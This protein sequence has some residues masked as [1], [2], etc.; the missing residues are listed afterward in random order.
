[1]D[2]R[3]RNELNNTAQEC[4]EYEPI[5]AAKNF[6]LA[7]GEDEMEDAGCDTCVHFNSGECEVYKREKY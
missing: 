5:Q 2:Y 1:V 7:Y 4:S 3:N 6:P